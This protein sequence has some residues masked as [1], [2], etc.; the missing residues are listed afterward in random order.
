MWDTWKKLLA[1]AGPS[2]AL[3]AI[4]GMTHQ[5]SFPLSLYNFAFQINKWASKTN[6]HTDRPKSM[7][8]KGM[9]I[10]PEVLMLAKPLSHQHLT[11]H[12]FKSWLIHFWSYSLWM[13][14]EKQWMMVQVFWS[15]CYLFGRTGRSFWLCHGSTQLWTSGY[16]TSKW[17]ISVFVAHISCNVQCHIHKM[18]LKFLKEL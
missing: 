1:P 6:T 13:A 4:W 18:H 17:K 2:L 11:G 15:Q 3:V 16:W 8:W 14:W 9:T 5:M 12:W 10:V 7:Q